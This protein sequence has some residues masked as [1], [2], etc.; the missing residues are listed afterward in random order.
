MPG[1]ELQTG[2]EQEGE[3]RGDDGLGAAE[4]Q[5]SSRG[6]ALGQSYRRC[7]NYE[8]KSVTT[9]FF[10]A[11]SELSLGELVHDEIFGLFEAMS[12]IEM[13]DPKMDV[14]IILNKDEPV[15]HTFQTAVSAGVLKLE[16]FTNEE[17]IGIFDSIYSCLVCWLE[18]HSLDQ[19]LFTCL[20]LHNPHEISDKVLKSFCLA[21]RKLIP[22]I[23]D[24]VIEGNVSEE[25][26][27]Q[28]FGVSNLGVID[29]PTETQVVG[30]L[31]ESEDE[32]VRRSRIESNAEDVLAVM[33]RVRL[34]RF[35][36]QSLFLL[37]PR[38]DTTFGEPVLV[39]VQKNLNAALELLPFIKRTVEKGTQ[40]DPKSDAP[41]PI[42]Y[43]PRVNQRNLPPTFPRSARIRDRLS[44]FVF[45]EGLSQKLKLAC[46][47]IH[48]KDYYA[49]LNFFIDFSKKSGQCLLSR[50][51]LQ[52]I[53]FGNKKNVKG[54]NPFEEFLKESIKLFTAPPI[55]M[56]KNSVS[57]NI[58]A[59][60]YVDSFLK[61][62]INLHTFTY[63][64]QI[65]GYN[66]A[67]QRDKLARLIEEGFGNLQDE[68][69][70]V[71]TYLN[72]ICRHTESS[73]QHISHFGTWTLYYCLRAMSLYLLSGFELELYSVHEFL[74]IYWYLYEFLF[75]FIVTTLSRAE[76]LL[77]M[78]DITSESKTNT[79][80]RKLKAK[81]KKQSKPFLRE[82]MYNHA[83][84]MMSGGY[85]KAI[86]AFT[87]DGRIR[88][89]KSKFD[90]EEIRFNRRFAPFANLN[91]PPPMPYIE[92]AKIRSS[93]FR[94][95]SAE[96]FL[97]AANHF[98]QA[99]NILESVLNPDT[100]MLQMIQVAKFNFIVTNLLANG[101]KKD[102]KLQPEFDFSQHYC[103]PI[104]KIN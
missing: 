99:R 94:A 46:K 66:R 9:E 8:W 42:G 91:S 101:H 48:Q 86:A 61:Y 53:F 14:G 37:W 44:S 57:N 104:I 27:F 16:N 64:L 95:P 35:L 40:P 84:Q 15:P 93:Q 28:L 2:S 23:K 12:A 102:S 58:E 60:K 18:G 80:Q 77:A 55:L 13:M 7:P 88:Q 39:E 10:E 76:S 45:L 70:R 25:E 92:F 78:Q 6:I 83:M 89:P 4:D 52:I 29:N 74:Y 103:F 49:T 85:Y 31:K 26:D 62:C 47:V 96:L 63:F 50:S 81:K 41:N 90:N 69:G 30:L 24:F 5:M 68:A 17:L 97:S 98:H 79:K 67:R 54:T 59:K 3:V 43:S 82:I 65:C 51:I 75:G 22:I 38:K 21:I 34:L 100:E 73:S 1:N 32:L 11:C 20:Y 87:K 36:F 72:L 71:D 56:S 33:H 19:I